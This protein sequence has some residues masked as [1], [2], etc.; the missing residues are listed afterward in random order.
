MREDRAA[1]RKGRGA[2]FNPENRFRRDA[3]EAC[4]DGWSE[5]P[6]DEEPPRLRTTVTIQNARTILAR[7]DSPDVPF[8]QSI[9][10][11][12]GCE[13]G[14]I[15]CFARPSHAFLD[16]SPGLDFE[17]R[18]FAKPNAPQLLRRELAKPGYVCDPIA[19]GTNTDPYQPIEREWKITRALLE[20]LCECEH[21]FTVVT[22][23][24][25]VER[26]IDLIAPMAAKNMARVA[27][28]ITTLD[29]SLARKLE[30]RASA[31]ERRLEALRNLTD[32][33]IPVGVMTAPIIPQLTDKDLE[34]ILEAAATH[35]AQFAGWVMLRLPREVS[36]LFR[37]WLDTHYP[38]RAAHVMSIVR[39][40][41]GGRD[42][43][44]SWGT[45]MRGSGEYAKLIEKRF[46]LA[47]RRF[48]L[49]R[50]RAVDDERTTVRAHFALDT[51]RFRPPVEKS[52]SG[53]L[54]LF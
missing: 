8:N 33:G 28:S 1:P 6:V 43:D 11:Y 20:V 9:N 54:D 21:P 26:D 53:Q 12:Q 31:P 40:I 38:Q 17:T 25:L 48:G 27:I 42:Y 49:N 47:C 13:H 7:N 35:G 45:R 39:Q 52:A 23:N 18:L 46:E 37:D 41:Q 24:A 22:K 30:P 3:R 10:P 29:R 51:T 16:L 32:A 50:S 4:D 2:T 34:A 15:Y 36:P 14:C 5:S 19:F 44:S